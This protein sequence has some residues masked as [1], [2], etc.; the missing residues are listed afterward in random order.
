MFNEINYQ[1]KDNITE[2]HAVMWIPTTKVTAILQIEHG[3]SEYIK[4][5]EGIAQLF[6][7]KGILVCGEDHLGHGESVIDADH[8]GYIAAKRGDR[9]L[10]DD[11]ITLTEIMK[12]K[13]PNVPYYILGHS[14]GSFIVR[15]YIGKYDD[16]NG[17]VIMGSSY[18]SQIKMNAA[19]FLTALEQFYHHGWFY[20]SKLLHKLTVGNLDKYFEDKRKF[21]WL[22]RSE[23]VLKNYEKDPLCNF[24][25]TCNGYLNMYRLIKYANK[26][27]T[28]KNTAKDLPLLIVSGKDDPVG[29]FGKGVDKIYKLYKNVKFKNV[30]LKMY[31]GMRHGIL[32]EPERIIVINDIIAFINS[33]NLKVDKYDANSK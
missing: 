23:E 2:I 4:R 9:I 20:R 28:Y 12:K 24:E 17:A 33:T 25:F 16:I 8:Y 15:N 19:I 6:N 14:F 30:K 5:Y 11:A 13:Y 26:K 18:Q 22:T 27:R 7:E 31:N 21:C 32:N 10:I 1:S 29:N 3:M